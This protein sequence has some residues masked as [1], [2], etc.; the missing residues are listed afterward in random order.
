MVVSNDSDFFTPI[1]M[2]VTKFQ[3]KI[4]IISPYKKKSEKLIR[5][6]NFFTLEIKKENLKDNQFS[7]TLSDHR[8]TFRKPHEW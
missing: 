5:A 4:G 7:D 2:V 8:G 1:E 6:S 3:K